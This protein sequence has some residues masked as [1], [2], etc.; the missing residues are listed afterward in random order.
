VSRDNASGLVIYL[1]GEYV[2]E[3]EAKVSVFDH[4][5]LYGDGVFEGIRAY[6]GRVFR[7]EEHIERLYE[8]AHTMMLDIPL[9][10]DEMADVVVRSC[11]YNSI[12]DGYI[13]LVVTRGK[14]DL[15]LDPRK[16][17]KATVF[18]IAAGIQLYPEVYYEKGLALITC[19]TRRNSPQ[20][21][22]PGL[23]SLNYLNN[24][25]AKIETV[26]AGVPE[27]IMLSID[28]Y[29]AEC[30]GDNI[31]VVSGGTLLTPPLHVGNLAGVTRKAVIELATGIGI[32][33]REDLFRVHTVYNAEEAFLS[34]TAA[35]IVPVTEVDGR[36]IGEGLPGPVTAKLL[37][38]YRELVMCEGVPIPEAALVGSV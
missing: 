23:K 29:V 4:G 38:A 28:G 35:E 33:V 9:T 26:R 25:L 19:A 13:R 17:G 15:G 1:D 21:L 34:G 24:I 10:R 27:G 3:E 12:R 22:D 8:G 32:P 36:K 11:A 7:L 5:L 37:A 30:T 6:H 31:F 16:C 18:C 20:T 2:P 14:G